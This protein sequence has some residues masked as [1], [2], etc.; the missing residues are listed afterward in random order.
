M[1][2]STALWA[3]IA[4]KDKQQNQTRSNNKINEEIQE[5]Y[6]MLNTF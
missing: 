5:S 4:N 2:F 3:S 1:T 6:G